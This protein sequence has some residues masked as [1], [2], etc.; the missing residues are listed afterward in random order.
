MT[1]HYWFMLPAA[2]VI[3]TVAMASGVGGATFFSPLF[4]LALGLSP[5]V[6]I[7]TG[8]IT[9]V[10]GFASGIYSYARKGY[11]DYR[12]AAALAVVTIPMALF[13]AWAAGH[14][15]PQIL[16]VILGVGLF[17][18][19]ASFLRSP[20]HHDVQRMDLAI[21]DEYGGEKGETCLVTTRGEKICY[22]VCNRTEGRFIAGVG[23]LFVGMIS[24]GL[25]E[26]NDYFLLQR[27]R[28]PSRISI[29]TGVFVVA[30]TAL[31]ASI[32]HL[33]RFIEAGGEVLTM[34]LSIV[35]F[36]VPGVILG[37]QF[38]SFFAGRIPQGML[39]RILGVLFIFIASLTLAEVLI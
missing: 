2:V 29:G 10:F 34:V 26:L 5:E 24:T 19:A 17:I 3:A 23:G 32:G 14:I 30:V 28:V 13:G 21:E 33:I 39:L 20:D 22:T 12:L 36:T 6:A 15:D 31:S 37:A 1:L 7:G 38:G 35:I 25:G 11:I 27:C 8:L 4:I 16:K 18:V 9:E